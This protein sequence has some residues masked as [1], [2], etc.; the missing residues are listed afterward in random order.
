MSARLYQECPSDHHQDF[1]EQQSQNKSV[2][3]K[4]LQKILDSERLFDESKYAKDC[5]CIFCLEEFSEMKKPKIIECP[6][7]QATFCTGSDECCKGIR[8]HLKNDNRCP[9][10]RLSADDW[11]KKIEAVKVES[12]SPISKLS[13]TFSISSLI[14]RYSL[15]FPARGTSIHG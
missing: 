5:S 1:E 13:L 3:D 15:T 4:N 10:C 9:V 7:C 11:V 8:Y 12:K 14:A 6:N 2:S